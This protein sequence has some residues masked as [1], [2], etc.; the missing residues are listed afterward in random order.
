MPKL[1]LKS[2]QSSFN[3]RTLSARSTTDR[4]LALTVAAIIWISVIFMVFPAIDLAVSR[5]LADGQGFS[6]AE[7][8][9]FKGVRYVGRQS[10]TYLLGAMLLILLLNIILPKRLRFCQPH[11]PIFVLL[12]FVAGPLV[13]VHALKALIGRARP[14]ALVEFGGNADFTPV[15]QFSMACESNCSFPSAGTSSA[16]ATLSLLV[17]IPARFRWI[18]AMVLTPCLA[19]IAFNRVIFGAHFLSDVVLGWLLTVFA[20]IWVWLW[21]D[22]QKPINSFCATP[23]LK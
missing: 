18:A 13:V 10:Q 17:F 15:W 7:H 11:K 9:F 23:S 6:L 8:P 21:I 4:A 14:R 2:S 19:L 1:P 5:S 20:M 3:E 12:S 16:A 22:R